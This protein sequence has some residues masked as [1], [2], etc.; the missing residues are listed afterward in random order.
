[1]S[2]DGNFSNDPQSRHT[3]PKP[4]SMP[5]IS[6]GWKSHNADKAFEK[7]GNNIYKSV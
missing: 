2:A 3:A 1:M 5:E 6:Q 4:V 7:N